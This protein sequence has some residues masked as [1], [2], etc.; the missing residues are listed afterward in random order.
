MS[1]MWLLSGKAGYPSRIES[2]NEVLAPSYMGGPAVPET[3]TIIFM[4]QKRNI[5]DGSIV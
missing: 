4:E 3:K 5:L 1:K 2:I